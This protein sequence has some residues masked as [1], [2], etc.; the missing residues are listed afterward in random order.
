MKPEES[1]RE[2]ILAGKTAL[3]IELGSTRIKGVLVDECSD[4]LAVGAHG[5]ENRYEDGVWTYTLDDVW[6]G[7]QHC[8]ADLAKDV[9]NRYGVQLT[10]IGSLGFSAMM[11]G[12][13]AFDAKG[14]LLSPFRT[15][16][17]VMTD[18]AAKELTNMFS[19]NIPL[20]W[21]VS[22]LWQDILDGKQHVGDV[23]FFTTLAGY[24]HWM[25]TGE[26]VL[27][28][29]D[30]SGM[31]PIDPETCTYDARMVEI[32]NREAQKKGIEMNVLDLLPEVRTAGEN[33]GLLTEK[34]AKRL[35]PTGRLTANVPVCPPEG[36]AGTGMV[37]TNSVLPRT[38]NVSA[39]TS[40][41][42][43]IVLEKPLNEVHPEIDI[44]MTPSGDP[45]A[46]VHCNTGTSDIDAWV[47]LLKSGAELFGANPSTEEMYGTLYRQALE[48][49]PDCGG[50]MAFNY[51]SGEV[52]TDIDAGSPLLFRAANSAF[53]IPNVMRTLLNS[54]LGTLKIGMDILADEDVE[55]D[56]IAGH[57][58]FFKT[59]MVGQSMMADALGCAVS[60]LDTAGE[61]GAWGISVL[62]LYMMRNDPDETLGTFLE[63]HVFAG[64]KATIVEPDQKG[65]EEFAEFMKRYR[66]ALP[67]E[68]AAV[69]AVQK[70]EL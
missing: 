53:T 7:V 18:Q 35:D 58:G 52:I 6:T 42:A 63:K 21:S 38:G 43:M 29:G 8:Y 40:I 66:D 1:I 23:A 50:L 15:W 9:E 47:Q 27:G 56:M 36:D 10:T 61:G 4:V 31:F 14:E 13:L 2:A 11:H 60:V 57:G 28:V 69:A 51:Y 45:V 67:V 12:L 17:N 39:G 41:F 34:G 65:S 26:K 70:R 44:V 25:C 49:D 54:S 32:F 19:F 68:A 64:S 3:G 37:A 22:H 5:W 55:V 30:A 16:R 33:A 62:A 59:R 24:V 46:M 48:A 20:R